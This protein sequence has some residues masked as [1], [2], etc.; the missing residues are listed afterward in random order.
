[1]RDF[2][3]DTHSY[4]RRLDGYQ[5]SACEPFLFLVAEIFSLNVEHSIGGLDGTTTKIMYSVGT[6]RGLLKMA[7]SSSSRD[8]GHMSLVDA[9]VL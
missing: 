4:D 3:A 6:P 1:V 5:C 9:Q 7:S 8:S 2:E